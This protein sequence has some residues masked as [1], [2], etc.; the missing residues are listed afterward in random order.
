M[1]KDSIKYNVWLPRDYTPAERYPSLYINNYGALSYNGMLAAA[2]INNFVN[3][4]NY[5]FQ[6]E[7]G[8]FNA[9]VLFTPEKIEDNQPPLN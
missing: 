3:S 7:P 2:H 9:Y 6:H 5:L 1:V 8:L 4:A